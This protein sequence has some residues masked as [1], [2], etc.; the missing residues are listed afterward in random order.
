MINIRNKEPGNDFAMAGMVTSKCKHIHCY[1]CCLVFQ[2]AAQQFEEASSGLPV[3]AIPGGYFKQHT[4]DIRRDLENSNAG[5]NDSL[6]DFYYQK[7]R[8]I[9]SDEQFYQA[10]RDM[11]C[12]LMYCA[13]C[14]KIDRTDFN[15]TEKVLQV[16]FDGHAKTRCTNAGC[17]F[18]NTP[19]IVE[20]HME[21]CQ[22][23]IERCEICHLEMPRSEMKNHL[24]YCKPCTYCEK[25]GPH[26]CPVRWSH[27][28]SYMNCYRMLDSAAEPVEER[29]GENSGK[30]VVGYGRHILFVAVEVLFLLYDL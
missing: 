6:E 8:E 19:E 24:V 16:K 11:P 3:V 22:H 13:M 17:T 27:S 5:G 25:R 15:V 4:E 10:I 30:F 20:F 7:L 12:T 21:T 26:D 18:M 29:I 2:K 23:Q 14:N 28:W 9:K 1:S